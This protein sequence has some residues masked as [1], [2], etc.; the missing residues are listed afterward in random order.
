MSMIQG[1][2][3]QVIYNMM[4]QIN[5]Q[6]AQF[7]SQN[8]GKSLEQIAKDYGVDFNLIKQFIH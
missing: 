7:V 5:P 6:F 4:M 2:D 8:Q 3:P 1:K